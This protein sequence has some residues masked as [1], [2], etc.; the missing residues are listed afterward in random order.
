[1]VV[2]VELLAVVVLA[3]LAYWWW[4]RGVIVTVTDRVTLHRIV[5][6]WWGAA[7]AAVTLAG[8]LL[9]NAGYRVFGGTRGRRPDVGPGDDDRH[10]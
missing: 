10:G 4:Q 9:L 7:T 6:A 8:F 5:G 3:L 2:V 1:M